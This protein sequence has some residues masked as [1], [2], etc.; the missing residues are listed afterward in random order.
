MKTLTLIV[1]A[2]CL[3]WVGA[4]S[5]EKRD[6]RLAARS[7]SP[8]SLGKAWP[9]QLLVSTIDRCWSQMTWRT[10]RRT[11]RSTATWPWAGWSRRRPSS[12]FQLCKDKLRMAIWLLEVA[13]GPLNSLLYGRPE[14]VK[15]IGMTYCTFFSS[16]SHSYHDVMRPPT[17]CVCLSVHPERV[18]KFKPL[19]AVFGESCK[20]K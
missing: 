19:F 5:V 17:P 14:L 18:D 3:A 9:F 13:P 8:L 10:W 12:T 11:W 16:F 6:T 2:V 1:L 15:P 4:A 20:I 7:G